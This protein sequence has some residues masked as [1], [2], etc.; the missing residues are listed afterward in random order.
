MRVAPV[1]VCHRPLRTRGDIDLD[2]L[3]VPCGHTVAVAVGLANR[4]PATFDTPHRLDLTRAP[5]RHLSF[6]RGT[7][8]C[9]GAHVMRRQLQ[10]ALEI[11]LRH[12]PHL[13]LAVG[14][15]Q[16][17]WTASHTIRSL[18]TLP[19]TWSTHR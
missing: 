13:D 9:L 4:D 15:T 3:H 10:I 11:L 16:L 19:L 14:N 6:G 12:L 1:R 2:G 5:N 18:K 17:G 7:H 8:H